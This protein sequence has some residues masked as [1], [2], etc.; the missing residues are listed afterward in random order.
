MTRRTR[1]LT[2]EE[3]RLWAAVAR[4]TVPLAGR[5]LPPEEALAKQPAPP[6]P[7][8][9][10]RAPPPAST[11]AAIKPLEPLERRKVRALSRGRTSADAILDLHGLTQVE[12][13][14]ALIHFLRRAQAAGHSLVLVVTGKG[15]PL[16]RSGLSGQPTERG[17]LRRMVPHWLALPDLRPLVLGFEEAGPRQGGGGALY[18]R[19]RRHRT[20]AER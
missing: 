13:H 14:G 10:P 4:A 3:R 17:V 18:V 1:M 11:P 19:L 9:A 5:V 7:P 15:A 8:P 6:S 16:G 2:P 12:A 20:P